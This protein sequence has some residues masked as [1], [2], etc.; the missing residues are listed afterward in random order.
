MISS[1]APVWS[2]EKPRSARRMAANSALL[3]VGR[4][5]SATAPGVCLTSTAAQPP[6]LT[7]LDWA[8]RP[9][10]TAAPAATP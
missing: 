9:T 8:V 1:S 4:S 7:S 6:S 3:L 2:P 5:A 10:N